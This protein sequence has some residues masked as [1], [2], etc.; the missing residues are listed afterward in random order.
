MTDTQVKDPA[1]VPMNV[2]FKAPQIVRDLAAES[3]PTWEEANGWDN[4]ELCGTRIPYGVVGY[5][6]VGVKCRACGDTG[7]YAEGSLCHACGEERVPNMVES[8]GVLQDPGLH[9]ES[10][11]WRRAREWVAEADAS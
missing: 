1:D 10:C 8:K 5:R 4:C 2:L 6:Q 11:V 3:F 9:S 7:H